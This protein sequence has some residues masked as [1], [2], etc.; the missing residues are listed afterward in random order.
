MR[1]FAPAAVIAG[2]ARRSNE[3]STASQRS[4]SWHVPLIPPQ[5]VFTQKPNRSAEPTGPYSERKNSKPYECLAWAIRI[6][7]GPSRHRTGPN[8][9]EPKARSARIA[10]PHPGSPGR[11]ASKPPGCM[12]DRTGM[13]FIATKA[14]LG[15]ETHGQGR[16]NVQGENADCLRAALH[17]EARSHQ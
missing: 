5:L 1:T 10:A 16:Q 17:R 14:Q 12:P 6:S 2:A 7:T 11:V 9:M 8:A 3:R 13:Q 4:K 15:N